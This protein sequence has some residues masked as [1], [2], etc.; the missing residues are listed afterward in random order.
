MVFGYNIGVICAIFFGAVVKQ[1]TSLVEV[2]LACVALTWN[3]FF[4]K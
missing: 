2:L 1:N 3:I 4:E